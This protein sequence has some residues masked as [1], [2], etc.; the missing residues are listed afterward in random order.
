[1]ATK[2]Y[3]AVAQRA[4]GGPYLLTEEALDKMDPAT[5]E[6]VQYDPATKVAWLPWGLQMY[7]GRGYWFDP[8]TQTVEAEIETWID[9]KTG[10]PAEAEPAASSEG[11]T[12]AAVDPIARALNDLRS[13]LGKAPVTRNE[14][15]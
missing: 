10:Q 2:T 15:R 12:E 3:N 13:M 8:T 14:G 9:P 7:L 11:E 5:A 6:V 1:M 4:E